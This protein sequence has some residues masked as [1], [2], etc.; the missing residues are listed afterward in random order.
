MNFFLVSMSR[1]G[2]AEM[3]RLESV[4]I[5]FAEEAKAVEAARKLAAEQTGRIFYVVKPVAQLQSNPT[6]VNYQSL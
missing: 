6:T 2:N 3:M 5:F 4:G 1:S